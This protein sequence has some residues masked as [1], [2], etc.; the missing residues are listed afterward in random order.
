MRRRGPHAGSASKPNTTCELAHDRSRRSPLDC[1]KFTHINT[2]SSWLRL[3]HI[4]P[5]FVPSRAVINC[6]SCQLVPACAHLQFTHN[7][8]APRSSFGARWAWQWLP[9]AHPQPGR[10]RRSDSSPKATPHNSCPQRAGAAMKIELNIAET[11]G[12]W[13][14]YFVVITRK[15]ARYPVLSSESHA[16]AHSLPAPRNS[17]ASRGPNARALRI[18]IRAHTQTQTGSAEYNEH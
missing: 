5:H 3:A 16:R 15:S 1:D 4:A 2:G 8:P 9:R 18:Y 6:T 7:E 14:L 17:L 12:C 10:T 11:I 13:R